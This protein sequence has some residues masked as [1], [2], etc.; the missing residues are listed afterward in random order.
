MYYNIIYAI[1]IVFYSVYS[2]NSVYHCLKCSQTLYLFDEIYREN[3]QNSYFIFEYVLKYYIF[4]WRKAEF[5]VAITSV[6][7][8]SSEIILIRWFA[9]FIYLF[10]SIIHNLWKKIIS[11]LI[12]NKKIVTIII[13]TVTFAQFNTPLLIKS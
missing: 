7:S 3:G 10:N 5:Q 11:G 1:Y 8:D 9:H 4:L 13:F 6:F 12:N 2:H